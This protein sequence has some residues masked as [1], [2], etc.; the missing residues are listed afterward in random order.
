MGEQSTHRTLGRDRVT[1]ALDRV[2]QA[3]RLRRKVTRDGASECRIDRYDPGGH[4]LGSARQLRAQ[5]DAEPDWRA[6]VPLQ[7]EVISAGASFDAIGRICADT[8]PDGSTR[9]SLSQH[10]KPASPPFMSKSG[11][12]ITPEVGVGNGLPGGVLDDLTVMPI[13]RPYHSAIRRIDL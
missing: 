12:G 4:P 7:P 13:P 5:T 2:R 10:G 6:A 1:Q 11:F 9:T 3:A 8:L